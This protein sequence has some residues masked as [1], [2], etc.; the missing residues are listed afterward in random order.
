MLLNSLLIDQELH[1]LPCF[2]LM[3]LTMPQREELTTVLCF[4]QSAKPIAKLIHYGL[5]FISLLRVMKSRCDFPDLLWN[6][7]KSYTTS[8]SYFQVT[9]RIFTL[10][11][12]KVILGCLNSVFPNNAK[13]STGYHLSMILEYLMVLCFRHKKAQDTSSR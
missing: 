7:C 10:T 4:S 2:W 6:V 8:N 12:L 5:D 13:H 1:E 3:F 9:F 11:S